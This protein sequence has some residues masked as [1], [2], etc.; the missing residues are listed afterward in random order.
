MISNSLRLDL[1]IFLADRADSIISAVEASGKKPTPKSLAE[2][3]LCLNVGEGLDLGGSREE[4]EALTLPK[5]LSALR[6]EAKNLV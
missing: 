2:F 1:G 6:S 4:W 3:A 5:K